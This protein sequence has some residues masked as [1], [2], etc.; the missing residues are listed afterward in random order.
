MMVQALHHRGPDARGVVE[1][2]KY[3]TLGHTRL[4]ILDLSEGANQ[5]FQSADGRFTLVFNGEIYNYLE[6][7]ETL[8]K[9]YAFR[10]QSDTEV[11]LYA[12]QEWGVSCLDQLLGMFAF[13]IWDAK[14]QLLFAAR[15]RFGVKPFYYAEKEG[16][17]YFASEIKALWAA[18]IP[19]KPK[20]TVWASYFVYGTY[21]MPNES[22]WE[23]IQPLPGGHYLNYRFGHLEVLRWYDFIAQV[24][25]M[26]VL[27]EEEARERWLGLALESI[28]LRFRSDVPVGFNVSGGLDSSLL[29]GLIGQ[30]FPAEKAVEAFSFYTGDSAYDEIPWVEQ[31]ISTTDFPL[32][33]VQ[34]Q[35]ADVPDL[36][37]EVHYFEDEPYGGIPTLAY[38]NLFKY[39]RK[40]GVLVLLDG[41]GIDEAWAGY[42]YYQR[43]T[44][45]LIQG[46]QGTV[47]RPDCLDPSF[48]SKAI[49]PVFPA[50]FSSR[51]QNLQYRDLFYTKIPR[52]LRFN[53]RISMMH[54]TE[55]RE[56]FLDHRLVELAFSLPA[57]MK[58]RNGQGKWLLRQ[59]ANELLPEG[60][61]LAPKR[62]LQTPQREWLAGALQ[63]WVSDRINQLEGHAW[64]DYSR[65]MKEWQSYIQGEQENSFFVWQWMSTMVLINK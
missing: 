53:D 52:A 17:L 24:E 16:R 30:N 11:L 21:G 20:E 28:Q 60:I 26:P 45:Q 7:R 64:F 50:P 40:K 47:F 2:D 58:I 31:A 32:N 42:D 65:V 48:R 29:I 37:A 63:P 14:T 57:T 27:S 34:L 51:L 49:E 5:P 10:T 39:A 6:L 4:R 59:L 54:S 9:D 36:A 62:P 41:Q 55:L 13:A 44:N 12:Y 35:V 61:A 18:G 33:K 46:T 56:P 19:K 8:E 1:V 23:G 43:D 38:A 3:A 15:D 22:F 25:R